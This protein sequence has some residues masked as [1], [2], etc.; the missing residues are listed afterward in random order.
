MGSGAE[1]VGSRLWLGFRAQSFACT[2]NW[3]S[4]GLFLWLEGVPKVHELHR[5]K[6]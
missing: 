2:R 1:G 4:G 6:L 5:E 3:A